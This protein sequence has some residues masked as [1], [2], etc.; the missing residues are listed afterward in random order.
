VKRCTSDNQEENE[1][2]DL[3]YAVVKSVWRFRA[4]EKG[5]RESFLS[6]AK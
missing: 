6:H 5:S 3:L 1:G 4:D 2:M